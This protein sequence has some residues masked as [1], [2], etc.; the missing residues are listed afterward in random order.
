MIFGQSWLS[1][2]ITIFCSFRGSMTRKPLSYSF[3]KVHKVIISKDFIWSSYNIH[4]VSLHHLKGPSS[5][6]SFHCNVT[7]NWKGSTFP[8]FF[9]LSNPQAFDHHQSQRGGGKLNFTWLA[10]GNLNQKCQDFPLE[11]KCY[12]I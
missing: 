3:L 7:I 9:S 5:S 11:C 6:S 2:M 4:F 1:S 12:I 8:P 10:S